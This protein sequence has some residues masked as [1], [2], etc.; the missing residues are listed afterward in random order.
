MK[1]FT[2]A[3]SYSSYRVTDG[4]IDIHLVMSIYILMYRTHGHT[5]LV[6]TKLAYI[7]TNLV[8][9]GKWKNFVI[10]PRFKSFFKSHD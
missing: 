3:T 8:A 7:L 2:L 5:A 10:P 9:D 6:Y 4:R 1:T